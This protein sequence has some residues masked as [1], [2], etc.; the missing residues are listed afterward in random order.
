AVGTGRGWVADSGV[1]HRVLAY[2]ADL[3]LTVITHAEDGGLT[4]DAVATEGETASRLGLPS[5]PAI[6]EALAIARDLMLAEE[7]GAKLHIR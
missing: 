5:A 1:M 4:A 7:T 3:G 2:A 6:A